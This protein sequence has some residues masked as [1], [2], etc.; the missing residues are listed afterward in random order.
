MSAVTSE[1]QEPSSIWRWL[2]PLASLVVFGF[3]A[4]VLHREIAHLHVRD[5]VHHL[6]SIPRSAVGAALAL[7]ALSYWLLSYYD[8]LAMRY[9]RK[10]MAYSRLLFT[11]FIAYAFGHN[12]GLAVDLTLVERATGRELKMGTGFDTFAASAHTANATGEFAANRQRLKSVMEAEG[13]KNLA[14]E[15]WH[16][17]YDVPDP[18]R[19]DR[20]IR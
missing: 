15:W 13:F 12:L 16:F 20:V 18:L 4:Y 1:Q 10:G 5:I 9:I 14:E 7:T 2:G 3:V 8:W 6:S 17:S 11:S 19:F